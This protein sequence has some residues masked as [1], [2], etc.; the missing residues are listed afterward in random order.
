[1]VVCCRVTCDDVHHPVTSLRLSNDG[2]CVLAGCLDA[3]LCLLDRETG[4]E[5]AT[6]RGHVNAQ[7]NKLDCAFTN[8]DA[9][10]VRRI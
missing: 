8:T 5:L 2:N 7:A 10:V 9:Y 1:L 3:P 4:E 6:Y